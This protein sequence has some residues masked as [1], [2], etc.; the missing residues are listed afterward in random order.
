MT[1]PEIFD[2]IF[3]AADFRYFRQKAFED[4]ESF[5]S[6]SYYE[7]NNDNKNISKIFII[8]A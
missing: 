7:L 6:M 5:H 3:D 1:Q 2:N 8:M 4:E